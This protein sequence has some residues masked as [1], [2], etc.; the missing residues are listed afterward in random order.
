MFIA[1]VAPSRTERKA[2]PHTRGP[3]VARD[4]MVRPHPSAMRAC[5]SAD[6]FAASCAMF[7]RSHQHHQF[8]FV[9]VCPG[10]ASIRWLFG[11]TFPAARGLCG[12]G[13]KAKTGGMYG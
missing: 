10:K 8:Q 2:G 5:A 6:D 9:P 11:S 1:A 3:D 4:K 12:N 13:R 7:P